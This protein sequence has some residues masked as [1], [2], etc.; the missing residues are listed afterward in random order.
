V[1]LE[2]A[3]G[4]FQ[5][6]E[7]VAG[8]VSLTER[9]DFAKEYRYV[10]ATDPDRTDDAD[11]MT[12]YTDLDDLEAAQTEADRLLALWMVDR[13]IYTVA[14]DQGILAHFIGTIFEWTYPRYDLTGGKHFVA[15]GVDEDMG[16]HGAPDRLGVTFFG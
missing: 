13:S 11:T 6:A 9:D 12:V 4:R 14:L 8:A 1:A 2:E 10:T 7:Q 15:V 5:G 3:R 16:E